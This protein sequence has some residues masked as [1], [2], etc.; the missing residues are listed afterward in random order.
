M[1]LISYIDYRHQTAQFGM[2]SAFT[3]ATMTCLWESSWISYSSRYQSAAQF[4]R[5]SCSL[6]RLQIAAVEQFPVQYFYC[7]FSQHKRQLCSKFQQTTLKHWTRNN[8]PESFYITVRLYKTTNLSLK[9]YITL[10]HLDI[11]TLLTCLNH[12]S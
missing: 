2:C 6:S 7:L 8:K 5:T 4:R 9:Y 3:P 10:M 11:Y 1:K 12:S